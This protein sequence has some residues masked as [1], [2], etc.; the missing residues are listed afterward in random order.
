MLRFVWLFLF[1]VHLYPA[2]AV[3][4]RFF[5]NPSLANMVSLFIVSGILTLAAL[6]TLDIAWLRIPL[7]RRSVLGIVL[8]AV[9]IHGDMAATRLPDYVNVE[10]TLMLS[11]SLVAGSSRFLKTVRTHLAYLLARASVSFSRVQEEAFLTFR[12]VVSCLQ[13]SPRAPPLR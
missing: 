8:L 9:W 4:L 11:V 5:K 10:S 1:V 12:V 13:A 7:H 3:S 2:T 6:K